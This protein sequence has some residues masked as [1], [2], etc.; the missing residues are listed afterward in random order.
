MTKSCGGKVDRARQGVLSINRNGSVVQKS[1]TKRELSVS[2]N[3]S[4]TIPLYVMRMDSNT[5]PYIPILETFK[6][7]GCNNIRLRDLDYEL[8][9]T[10]SDKCTVK[11]ATHKLHPRL[12]IPCAS[13]LPTDVAPATKRAVTLTIKN[14]CATSTR[15]IMQVGSYVFGL[16]ST[17]RLGVRTA[18]TRHIIYV[19]EVGK[20]TG[21]GDLREGVC[22]KFWYFGGIEP[23]KV[24]DKMIENGLTQRF[25][26]T[27][28]NNGKSVEYKWVEKE[29]LTWFLAQGIT[30]GIHGVPR[31]RLWG[32]HSNDVETW[33]HYDL[34]VEVKLKY[35]PFGGAGHVLGAK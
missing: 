22:E 23:L 13:E 30:P 11:T 32:P 21:S 28:R 5:C 8:S 17:A 4:K 1:Q 24:T 7:Y 10:F 20:I 3:L 34:A 9:K 35:K 2:S 27:S 29:L 14:N 26:G 25:A 16:S 31:Q 33:F 19:A 12:Y 15:K 6:E 18:P